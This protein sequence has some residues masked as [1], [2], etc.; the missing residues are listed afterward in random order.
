MN[1]HFFKWDF[2]ETLQSAR[3]EWESLLAKVG[4]SNML[5]PGVAGEWSVKDIICHITWF[6]REMVGVLQARALIGSDLWNLPQGQRNAAVFEKNRYRP[7]E[8]VLTEA[9]QVY[10]G[11]YE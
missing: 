8:D 10:Q 4:E 11:L 9:R 1:E 2:L 3:A 5:R 6:E 7:L